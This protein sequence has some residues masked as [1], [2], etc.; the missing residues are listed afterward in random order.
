VTSKSLE[1]AYG[2]VVWSAD[3]SRVTKSRPSGDYPRRRFKSELR[4]NRLLVAQPPPVVFPALIE[5]ATHSRSL[6]F[7][8]LPGDPLGPKYP[9][10]LAAAEIDAILAVAQALKAYNPRRRWLHRIDPVRRIAFA[11]R[12]GLLTS[13]VATALVAVA[14]RHGRPLR[15]AH[16]DL[17]ARNVLRHGDGVALIDWEW[18]GL[19][20]P[21]YDEA[22]LWYTLREVEDA[23]AHVER[24]IAARVDETSFLLCA[25]LVE[26]WHVQW[27]VS[28]EYLPAH[29]ATRDALIERLC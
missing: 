27:F 8:A 20:P 15:F 28:A 6:T 10:D 22:F 3:G 13:E 25:L 16:G 11:C 4:V 17:T 24:A 1:T 19:Y 29:L 26:L 5:H 12:S 23:R 21:G 18:A 14:R 2:T 9:S 7:E